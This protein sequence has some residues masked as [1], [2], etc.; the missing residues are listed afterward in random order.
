[1]EYADHTLRLRSPGLTPAVR[2]LL[3]A[4]SAGFLAQQ[5]FNPFLMEHFALHPDQIIA[6][7]KVWQLLSYMFLHGSLLHLFFNLFT[8]W[9]FGGDV[10]R[11]LGRSFFLRLYFLSGVGGGLLQLA[12]NWGSST[13]VIGA[14]AAVYGVL[15]AFAVLFPERLITLLLFFIIPIQ[16]RARTLAFLF[17]GASLLFGL[18][19]RLF[20]SVDRIAHFAHLGGAVTAFVMLRG[21]FYLKQFCNTVSERRRRRQIEQ[22]LLRRQRIDEIR[23][24]IDAV[25]DRINEVGYDRISAD[26]KDFLKKAGKLL[27]KETDQSR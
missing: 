24:R 11:L 10:E 16:M 2:G 26:E 15:V 8:L 6:E 18:Q 27:S 12:L 21:S 1:M 4:E 19:G 20:G 5:L 25:L 22:E 9:M 7:W 13:A 23:R 14:S 17:V 3:I